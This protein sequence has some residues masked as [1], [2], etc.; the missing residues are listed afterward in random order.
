MKEDRLEYNQSVYYRQDLIL[1]EMMENFWD[2]TSQ[3]II[4]RDNTRRDEGYE[5]GR[6]PVSEL[7]SS[8]IP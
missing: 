6:D 8:L 3:F 5:I 2:M 4:K 1:A 7:L